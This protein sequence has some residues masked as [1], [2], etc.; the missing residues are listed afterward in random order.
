[1]ADFTLKIEYVYPKNVKHSQSH[2]PFCNLE[3]VMMKKYTEIF[4]C[5]RYLQQICFDVEFFSNYE[6]KT[7]E[8]QLIVEFVLHKTWLF[9]FLNSGKAKLAHISGKHW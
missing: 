3:I 6:N 7:S 9:L 5:I 1:M 4:K 8:A 2:L